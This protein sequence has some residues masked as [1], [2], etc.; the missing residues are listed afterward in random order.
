MMDE[1]TLLVEKPNNVINALP[2]DSFGCRS[3]SGVSASKDAICLIPSGDLTETNPFDRLGFGGLMEAK[4]ITNLTHDPPV[5]EPTTIPTPRSDPSLQSPGFGSS[6]TGTKTKADPSTFEKPSRLVSISP[7]NSANGAMLSSLTHG[8]QQPETST[9]DASSSLILDPQLL[10]IGPKTDAGAVFDSA[11][12][13][14]IETG[15]LVTHPVLDTTRLAASTTTTGDWL[16]AQAQPERD[17]LTTINDAPPSAPNT[18]QFAVRPKIDSAPDNTTA[19]KVYMVNKECAVLE[20]QAAPPTVKIPTVP[21]NEK[22]ERLGLEPA[23]LDVRLAATELSSPRMDEPLSKIK[24]FG[25]ALHAESDLGHPSHVTKPNETSTRAPAI[26]FCKYTRNGFSLLANDLMSQVPE[27][28]PN[29]VS[30]SAA[31]S[32]FPITMPARMEPGPSKSELSGDTPEAMD[33]ISR[34]RLRSRS[35]SL[36]VISV[37]RVQRSEPAT[38]STPNTVRRAPLTDVFIRPHMPASASRPM[39]LP[40]SSRANRETGSLGRT[41]D[42]PQQQHGTLNEHDS[43]GKKRKP[44]TT[45]SAMNKRQKPNDALSTVPASPSESPIQP[46][47]RA[48]WSSPSQSLDNDPSQVLSEPT[49]GKKKAILSSESEYLAQRDQTLSPTPI[50]NSVK[51][52]HLQLESASTSTSTLPTPRKAYR[53]I[54]TSAM[55]ADLAQQAESSFPF[56]T[57]AERH[58]KTPR[59]VRDVFSAIVTFPLLQKSAQGLEKVRG[60]AGQQRMREYKAAEKET[61][62]VN[63]AEAQK[64]AKKAKE[65]NEVKKA[66]SAK[67]TP[68]PKVSRKPIGDGEGSTKRTPKSKAG[69]GEGS[70]TT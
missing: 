57:F 49:T 70:C 52:S 19:V 24:P 10:P 9:G 60:G 56:A 33:S 64:E 20:L 22:I 54:W 29:P 53:Q 50:Q 15:Q 48:L 55:Y 45:D 58:S 26:S 69:A 14:A 68:K 25:L 40:A 37:K 61:A 3:K 12:P 66:G 13:I 46:R 31:T 16:A 32:V 27:A 59:E 42:R 30:R 5:P 8:S 67:A 2:C 51:A 18:E 6:V 36:E 21:T 23:G 35:L 65:A 38:P 47:N 7:T 43:N 44:I 28:D 63:K 39:E 11:S 17:L 34:S 62:K 41:D 1:A 4:S